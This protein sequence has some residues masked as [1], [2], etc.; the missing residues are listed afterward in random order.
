ML[1]VFRVSMG[2]VYCLPSDDPFG[3][4]LSLNKNAMEGFYGILF[5]IIVV[6]TTLFIYMNCSCI[7]AGTKST[8][9]MYNELYIEPRQLIEIEG[10]QFNEH[11]S[12]VRGL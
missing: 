2:G 6:S 3:P 7:A 8:A 10:F 4:R 11:Q 5:Y 1:L 9:Y 12:N